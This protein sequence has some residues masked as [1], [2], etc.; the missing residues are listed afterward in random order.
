MQYQN[1]LFG[2]D[3]ALFQASANGNIETAETLISD[4]ANVNAMS[5]NG[6]TPM[7]RAAENGHLAL[8]KYLLSKNA[9][10]GLK[11]TADESAADLAENN[12]HNDIA[13]T[14]RTHIEKA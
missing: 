3:G 7:H 10:P 5:A 14:I 2:K 9:N 6:Y 13:E 1:W 12:G 8:V 11:S 4:G